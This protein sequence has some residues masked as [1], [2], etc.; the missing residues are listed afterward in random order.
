MASFGYIGLLRKVSNLPKEAISYINSLDSI[1]RTGAVLAK[2][3]LSYTRV[4]Q[5]VVETFDL[6]S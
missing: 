6:C 5:Y 3:L 4:D 1:T 2:R